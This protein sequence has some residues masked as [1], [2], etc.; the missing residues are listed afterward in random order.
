MPY[1]GNITVLK[2]GK[3]STVAVSNGLTTI[4]LKETLTVTETGYNKFRVTELDSEGLYKT[5]YSGYD[6]NNTRI[7]TGNET[8]SSTIKKAV[9]TNSYNSLYALNI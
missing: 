1:S 7:I 8:T 9:I 3:S 2:D 4:G 6:N 5:E